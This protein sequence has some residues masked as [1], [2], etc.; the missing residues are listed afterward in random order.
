MLQ[1]GAQVGT[2]RS[3]GIPPRFRSFLHL[4]GAV[5][6]QVCGNVEDVSIQFIPQTVITVI[7]LPLAASHLKTLPLKGGGGPCARF[8]PEKQSY[9]VA[10]HNFPQQIRPEHYNA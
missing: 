1:C 9:R 3:S 5:W 4:I 7:M 6:A 10:M 2:A 8:P